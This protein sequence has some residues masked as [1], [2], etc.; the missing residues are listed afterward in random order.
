MHKVLGWPLKTTEVNSLPSVSLEAHGS[1][2]RLLEVN[3]RTGQVLQPKLR[4]MRGPVCQKDFPLPGDP[5]SDGTNMGG[6]S[7]SYWLAC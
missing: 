3:M 5:V 2:N 6:Y 4:A 7:L 1:V